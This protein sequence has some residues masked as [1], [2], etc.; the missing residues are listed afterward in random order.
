MA[1]RFVIKKT[2]GGQFRAYFYHNKEA[3]F[4][5]ETYTRRDAA[6]NAIQSILKN[7]P[8]APIEEE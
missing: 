7:G 8:T 4:W 1:H 5:T 6:R 2:D 3:I